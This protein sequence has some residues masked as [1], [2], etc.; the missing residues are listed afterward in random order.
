MR[1]NNKWENRRNNTKSNEK[2]LMVTMRGLAAALVLIGAL[3]TQAGSALMT[4]NNLSQVTPGHTLDKV[5]VGDIMMS[6]KTFGKGKPILLVH[7]Y[8]GSM[9]VWDTTMLKILAENHTVIVFNNRG[10][11]N[12]TLGERRYSIPQLAEDAAGLLDTLGIPKTDVL[13]WSVGGMIAQELALHYPDKVDKLILYATS[14]GG[15]DSLLP[16]KDALAVFANRSG[17]PDERLARIVPF[18]F[19]NEWI[20]AHPDYWTAI[21]RNTQISSNG[22]LDLELDAGLSWGGICNELGQIKRPTLVITGTEDLAMPPANSLTIAERIPGAWLIQL[23]HGGHGMMYQYPEK[24]GMLILT[25]LDT[26]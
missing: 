11:G 14:C 3:T 7:G 10:V 24:I 16:E 23:E 12:T 4:D 6:Y 15:Q 25:F 1:D 8:G 9:D 17:T 20:S 13:G 22:T 26:T 21:P 18:L 2:Y 5:K 19:T